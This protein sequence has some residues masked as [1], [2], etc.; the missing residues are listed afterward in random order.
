MIAVHFLDLILSETIIITYKLLGQVRVKG[1]AKRAMLG[2][3][4]SII[5]PNVQIIPVC[6]H[7]LLG[8]G[9][10][11]SSSSPVFCHSKNIWFC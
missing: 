11:I 8:N 7:A 3:A 2:H 4:A 10:V 5:F 1:V 6:M 9:V